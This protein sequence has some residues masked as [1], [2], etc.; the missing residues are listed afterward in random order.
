MISVDCNGIATESPF[1]L[2][3]LQRRVHPLAGDVQIP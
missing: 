1:I 3:A 2:D